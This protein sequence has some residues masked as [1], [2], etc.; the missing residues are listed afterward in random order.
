MRA[1][2]QTFA[3]NSRHVMNVSF[4]GVSGLC[5]V[6]VS[7]KHSDRTFIKSM[8]LNQYNQLVD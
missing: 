2:E 6:V 3:V 7:E 4:N 5:D 1:N 8:V